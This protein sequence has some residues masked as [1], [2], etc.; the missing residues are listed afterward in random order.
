MLVSDIKHPNLGQVWRDFCSARQAYAQTQQEEGTEERDLCPKSQKAS[1]VWSLSRGVVRKNTLPVRPPNVAQISIFD[2][3]HRWYKRPMIGPSIETK[4]GGNVGLPGLAGGPDLGFGF[5]WNGGILR[6]H[7]VT[8]NQP[9][10]MR[11]ARK[12]EPI[13]GKLKSPRTPKFEK[14]PE[15]LGP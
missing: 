12:R 15:G 1:W 14:S 3:P 2:C 4:T 9:I 7:Q 5:P 6:P 11:L 8:W 13:R 10:D